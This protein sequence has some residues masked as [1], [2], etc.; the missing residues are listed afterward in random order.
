MY[1]SSCDPQSMRLIDPSSLRNFLTSP[2]VAALLAIAAGLLSFSAVRIGIRAYAIDR[3][4]RAMESRIQGLEVEKER[5]QEAIAALDTPETVERLAK[6]R[7]NLK[8]PGEEVVV[9]TPRSGE[10]ASRRSGLS[11]FVPTWLHELFGFLWR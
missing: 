1:I 2:L 7:L 9:I 3:E 4:Q 5:L 11:R 8:N 6:E 10:T